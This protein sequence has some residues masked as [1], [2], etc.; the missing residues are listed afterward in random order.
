MKKFP[1]FYFR[2]S[3]TWHY[4]P[5]SLSLTFDS[6]AFKAASVT[7]G[8]WFSSVSPGFDMIQIETSSKCNMKKTKGNYCIT[9][10]DLYTYM[11]IDF[12]LYTYIQLLCTASLGAYCITF[13]FFLNN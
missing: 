3:Y 10:D 11:C 1:V 8:N 12:N 2:F 7:G 6:S 5:I 4:L 9:K 13:L